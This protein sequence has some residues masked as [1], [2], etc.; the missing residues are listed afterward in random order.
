M[1]CR[2]LELILDKNNNKKTLLGW[3]MKLEYLDNFTT[4]IVD[5]KL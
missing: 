2:I 1:Q 5:A 4:I 3:L